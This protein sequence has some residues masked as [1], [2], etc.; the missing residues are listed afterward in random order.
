[1]E[2]DETISAA[3]AFVKPIHDDMARTE[4][5]RL[6]W[7]DGKRHLNNAHRRVKMDELIEG[8]ESL[9]ADGYEDALKAAI[10]LERISKLP[11]E[12]EEAEK[13]MA[14]LPNEHMMTGN[15]CA[16]ELRATWES[17]DG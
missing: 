8:L 6:S 14:H 5:Q 16:D 2:I 11:G 12:W 13:E 4:L 7:Q 10:I 1:M 9:G 3:F 15:M 17:A